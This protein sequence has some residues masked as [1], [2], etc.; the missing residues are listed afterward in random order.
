MQVDDRILRQ[1]IWGETEASPLPSNPVVIKSW[2]EYTVHHITSMMRDE[3]LLHIRKSTI[4]WSAGSPVVSSN[5]VIYVPL[6]S[7]SVIADEW[8]E[9]I[10]A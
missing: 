6:G 4:E 10:G 9:E 5:I 3:D 8:R 7:I 2:M 1:R